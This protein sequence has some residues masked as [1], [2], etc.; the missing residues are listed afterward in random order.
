MKVIHL[1]VEFVS[2]RLNRKMAPS[3]AGR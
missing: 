3:R 1:E 2:Y